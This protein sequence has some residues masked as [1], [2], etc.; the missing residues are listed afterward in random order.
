M[1]TSHVV[2][3]VP[4]DGNPHA[5]GYARDKQVL[6]LHHVRQMQSY[7]LDE[8]QAAA[9]RAIELRA[10]GQGGE[11]IV[12]AAARVA[13]E[14]SFAGEARPAGEDSEGGDLA[15]AQ[16][17]IGAWP[18]FFSRAGLV[19][20]VDCNVEYGEEGVHIEHEGSVPF[21]WGLGGKPTLECGHLPLKFRTANS[22]QAF[23]RVEQLRIKTCQSSQ[24]L[25]V[26]LGVF[27][28]LA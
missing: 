12:Q 19:K 11:G 4:E 25:S 24:I 3:A 23:E 21:P 8:T 18:L 1:T 22:H 28:L 20:V 16:G 17:R 15:G 14:I 5:Y 7:L 6:G 9:H 27:C 26:Y 10:V 13:V 2:E